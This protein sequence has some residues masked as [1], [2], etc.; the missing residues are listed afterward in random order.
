MLSL[1]SLTVCHTESTNKYFVEWMSPCY[2]IKC[3]LW[4][5]KLNY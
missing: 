2:V 5:E 4:E 3:E 1:S